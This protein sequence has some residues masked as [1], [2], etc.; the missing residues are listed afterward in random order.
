MKSPV[1][2][3]DSHIL[4]PLDL[5][6]R[7]LEPKYQ[8]RAM[9][10]EKDSQGWEQWIINGKPYSYRH[11]IFGD[12][13]AIG[14]DLKRYFTPGQ[15]TYEEGRQLS[16]GGCDPHERIKVLDQEGIDT[17]LLYPSL[18]ITWE[19]GCDDAELADAYC[20]AYNN[21][22]IEWCG[23]YPERLISVAHISLM[24]PRLGAEELKRAVKAGAK[25]AMVRAYPSGDRPFGHPDNDVFWATAQDLDIPVAL[26]IGGAKKLAGSEIA[27]TRMG[28]N[29][30]WNY[31]MFMTELQT[32][33]T[34]IMNGAV[35]ERFPRLKIVLLESGCGWIAYWLSRM[36]DTFDHTGFSTPLKQ[37]PSEYFKRQCFITMDADE[38]LA[39]DTI[40]RV[41]AQSF[42]WAADYPHSDGHWN[43]AQSVRSVLKDLSQEDQAK[44]L[45]DNAIQAYHLA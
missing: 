23:A 39:P 3:A 45:G 44:V 13:G 19:G 32:G 9:R 17:V 25:G 15:A 40:R 7:Y 38:E 28:H 16:P 12:M 27:D 5:W 6:Q 34:S 35:L 29:T 26:H 11:G 14:Q 24:D 18:G 21:W 36:D 10:I 8:D 31:V 33:I 20:R 1:I 30:W 4:E 41:G 42:M 22:L 37:H 43:A 2:D